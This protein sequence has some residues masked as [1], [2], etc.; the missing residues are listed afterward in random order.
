[1]GADE[2]YGALQ[3]RLATIGAA[4]LM[5]AL[6]QLAAGTLVATAQDHAT[7]TL[8]PLIRKEQGRIDWRQPAAV[9]ARQVRGFNPW[10]SAHTTLAGRLLKIH[11]ARAASGGGEPGRVV[12]LDD[13][14]RVATGDG[15]LAIAQLQLEGRRALSA[16]EF[17]RGGTL[18]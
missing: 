16:E 5:A 9:I 17:A 18:A 7:A 15:V 3:T 14:V 2:S 13:A 12:A 8:A 10:P 11:A 4:A 6:A 1:I